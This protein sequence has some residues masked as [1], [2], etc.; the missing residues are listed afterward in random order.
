MRREHKN[1]VT[2]LKD[3]MAARYA[4]ELKTCR[5]KGL[6]HVLERNI[7]RTL[8]KFIE[9]LLSFS[10]LDNL[11][12]TIVCRHYLREHRIADLADVT[13]ARAWVVG[14]KRRRQFEGI[15]LKRHALLV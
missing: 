3:M 5:F 7:V 2:F 10:H 1:D 13:D 9:K 4:V 14:N 6:A 15:D 12:D 8:A 11:S